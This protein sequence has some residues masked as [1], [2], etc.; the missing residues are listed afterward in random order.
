MNQLKCNR[1]SKQYLGSVILT[2]LSRVSQ[3]T[4]YEDRMLG[5]L[6]HERKNVAA[7]TGC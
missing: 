1:L 3:M 5:K 4:G 6:V 7:Y 2:L